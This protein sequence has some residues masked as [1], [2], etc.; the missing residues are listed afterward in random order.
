MEFLRYDFSEEEIRDRSKKL[1]LSVQQ[2]TQAQEEHKAA[3]SQFKERIESCTS[4]I[5]RLSREINSGWEMRNIECAVLF[6]NPNLGVKTIVRTDTG[7]V[8]R[9]T[10]MQ[11]SEL[12]ENLFEE[13]EAEVTA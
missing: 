4:Q 13:Q 10:S 6:H 3:A 12:Q 2:Q 5:G 1:A 7:E 8:V 11:P 9:T